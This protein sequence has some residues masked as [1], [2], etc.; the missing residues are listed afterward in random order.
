MMIHKEKLTIEK[1]NCISYMVGKPKVLLIQPVDEQ[2]IAVLDKQV[3]ILTEE[4]QDS[5]LLIALQIKN[6]NKELSPWPAPAIFGKD[7]FGDGAPQTL[8]LIE[9][10]LIEHV[11]QK[12]K[13][14]KN[15][16]VI[17]GAIH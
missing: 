1:T 17:L 4:L 7:D 12:Y 15:T 9:H 8:S 6:W 16:P 11:H 2:D 14:H 5:F 10:T 3:E 13:L